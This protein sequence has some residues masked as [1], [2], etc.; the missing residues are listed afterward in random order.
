MA[1]VLSQ[2]AAAKAELRGKAA[3][4]Y[5]QE[6]D[7]LARDGKTVEAAKMYERAANAI[8]ADASPTI[9]LFVPGRLCLFGEHSDWAG[10]S[11]ASIATS[12]L[13]KLWSSGRRRGSRRV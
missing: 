4:Q 9:D 2:K 12:C 6:A 1:A 13:V 3:E 11:G 10:G 7:A 5:A 8:Q